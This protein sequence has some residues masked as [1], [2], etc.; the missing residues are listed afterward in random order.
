MLQATPRT[1]D[2]EVDLLVIGGGAGG[3]TAAL[4][5]ALEGLETVLC[6]KTEHGRRHHL[7]IRRHDL[8]PGTSQSVKAGVPD[9]V[10]DAAALSGRG[11]SAR[12][13]DEQRDAFLEAGPKAIDYLEARSDVTFIPAQAHPDYIGNQPGAAYGG[14]ALAPAPFDGRKLGEDFD[15]VRPPRPEFHGARRDDDDPGGHPLSAG[16]RSHPSKHSRTSRGC[17]PATCADRLRYKRGT[18]LVMGN[19]LVA[20]LLYSL[21]KQKVPI[22]FNT[23]LSEL[24][25][26]GGPSSARC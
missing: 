4:V 22:Q 6:E 15:R 13:G 19:A 2:E 1:W 20:R 7:D 25:A 23:A 3:M 10:D 26:E 24:V 17:S 14:R 16:A 5:G 8:G 12:G 9:S 21:R 11:R 18:N